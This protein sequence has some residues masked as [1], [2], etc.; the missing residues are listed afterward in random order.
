MIGQ[1]VSHYRILEKLGEGGMGVVY[2]AQ[3][4]KLDRLVAL[5]FLPHH[6]TAEDTEKARFL[7]EAKAASALNHPNVCTIYGIEEHQGQQFIEMEFVDGKTLREV[8]QSA[9]PKPQSAISYAIQIGE[10]LQEAHGKGIV[11]RDI[12]ADNIM[13]NTKNQVKVMDFGLA[14]LKGSL[15]LTRSSSTVGTL[16]YMA[17]EQIQGGEVDARSDIFSFGVVLYEMLTGHTPFR[18]EH[19]AAMMYS[20]LNEEPEPIHKYL[21][22]VSPEFLHVLNRALE[23]DPEDRY[24]TVHDMVIDLRRLKRETS[25]V[26]RAP[27]AEMPIVEPQEA[28]EPAS[29]PEFAGKI[30]KPRVRPFVIPATIAGVILLAVVAYLSF[31]GEEAETAERIPVAVID[32]VNETGEKELDGL[33]GMLIT[34]LE[35]SRRLAVLTRSR[36]FDILKHLGKLDVERIDERLGRE[37]CRQANVNALVIAS[38]RKFGQLYTIDLKIIDPQKNEYLF[39]ARAEG[40]GQ[41]RVPSMIDELSEKTRIGLKEKIA[42]IQAAS[43]NVAKVTTSN[44][45]AYHHYFLG[46]QL[47]DKLKFEEAKEEFKKAIDLDATFGVAYYR[48]AYAIGWS[49]GSERLAREPMRK[50]L[51]LIDRIPEKERY[52][53]RALNAELEEGYAAGVAV[54]KEM[55]R[56]YPNDKE[57][58][59]NI[60]DWSFHAGDYTTAVEYL[61]KVLNIDPTFERALQ[62]LTW[63]YQYTGNYEEMLL[64]AKQYASVAGTGE[65]YSLLGDAYAGLSEFDSGL[66]A[67]QQAH[68]LFP[69]AHGITRAIADLYTFRGEYRKAEEQLRRL[70]QEQQPL[71]AKRSGYA[72]LSYFYPYLGKYRDA[73]AMLEKRAA[74]YWEA[75]DTARASMTQVIRG[76]YLSHGWHDS[77]SALREA[78]KTASFQSAITYIPYWGFLFDLFLQVGE[79]ERAEEFVNERFA[80]N[81]LTHRSALSLLQS[82]KGRCSEARAF[83]DSVFQSVSADTKVWILYPLAVCQFEH[84]K[85]DRAKES[86]IQIQSLYDNSLGVRAVYYP[87]S[88][89]LLGRIYEKKG[90]K[91]LA[92][93][94]FEKFLDLWKEA[95]EDLPELIDAKAR[96]AKLKGTA[97]R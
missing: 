66:R 29:Q 24:Q 91:E 32:F 81:K 4:T 13:V 79:L 30:Q 41:E 11:H 7:Q 59:Y 69:E 83:A 27:V 84:G 71:E 57:M 18:G 77:K 53:V 26:S 45:E 54:L 22:D 51:E 31:F 56:S 61:N 8:I 72:G 78:E 73:L 92:I 89:Y 34:S 3:D 16:A 58:T 52:L 75:E 35:Q 15:K 82:A 55:E 93:A 38:I 95:D 96:L 12:K 43:E 28:R 44:L 6:L 88:M 20:I 62:H 40:Q 64:V 90:E 19:D 17:P 80:R 42:E 9:I 97:A 49:V 46:E 50:A 23:K 10:A 37:V 5:K 25:R 74:L 94:N 2:K 63:T 70:V 87:K 39:A 36:M 14:K 86:L 60:G 48:L 68:D 21:P 65:A 1:I 76:L 85:L 33:S 47:V 67:L